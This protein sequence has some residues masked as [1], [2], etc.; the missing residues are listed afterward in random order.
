M[1]LGR[2]AQRYLA[3]RHTLRQLL[4]GALNR[5]PESLVI[6]PDKFGKPHLADGSPLHFNL[7][8]SG[9]EGLI[10]VSSDRAIS[11]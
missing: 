10:G 1:A 2:D 7:S 6:E 3:S 4:A 5:S 11:A 9:H 8:H